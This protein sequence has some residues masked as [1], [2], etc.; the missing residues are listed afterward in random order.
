MISA[1]SFVFLFVHHPSVNSGILQLFE[2]VFGGVF[3]LVLYCVELASCVLSP[4]SC[5][6]PFKVFIFD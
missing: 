3:V 4:E 2:E 1:C 6:P 5:L